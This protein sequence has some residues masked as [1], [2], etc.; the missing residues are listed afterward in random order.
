MR[1]TKGQLEMLEAAAKPGGI[2]KGAVLDSSLWR[3]LDQLERRGFVVQSFGEVRYKAYLATE[4]GR[5][6][7]PRESGPLPIVSAR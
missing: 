2:T 7:L 6:L 1:L 5:R 3:N 4:A